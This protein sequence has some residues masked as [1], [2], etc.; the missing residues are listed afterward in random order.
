VRA[1]EV[2]STEATRHGA[3]VSDAIIHVA[4]AAAARAAQF[5]AELALLLGPE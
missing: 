5:C 3:C 2:R 4:S 1:D